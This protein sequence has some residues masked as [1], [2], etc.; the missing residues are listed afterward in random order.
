MNIILISVLSVFLLSVLNIAKAKKELSDDDILKY[1]KEVKPKTIKYYLISMIPMI[2][3]AYLFTG[4][5]VD[6]FNTTKYYILVVVTIFDALLIYQSSVA[7]KDNINNN[8][9]K[10]TKAFMIMTIIKL[11][12]SIS[13]VMLLMNLYS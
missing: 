9:S 3:L 2:F 10:T 13:V 11:A 12:L 1:E 7:Y 4:S 8:L 6:L 5:N